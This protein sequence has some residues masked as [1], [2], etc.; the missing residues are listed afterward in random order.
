MQNRIM[1]EMLERLSVK[2]LEVKDENDLKLNAHVAQIS[3]TYEGQ[4]STKMD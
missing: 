1:H 3:K 2:F 4:L